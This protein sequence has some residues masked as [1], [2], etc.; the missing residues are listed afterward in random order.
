[1]S[2]ELRRIMRKSPA[3]QIRA[4]KKSGRMFADTWGSYTKCPNCT[5]PVKDGRTHC[6]NC[7]HAMKQE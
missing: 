3:S 2:S 7:D 4:Y 6:L 1:V 5:Y